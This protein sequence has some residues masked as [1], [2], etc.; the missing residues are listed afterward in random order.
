MAMLAESNM[1]CVRA[2]TAPG[3]PKDAYLVNDRPPDARF[4]A[5]ILVVVAHPDDET[6]VTSYL[7]REIYEEHKRV[8]VVYGTRGDAGN[9]EVGPENATAMGQIREIEA[10]QAVG[11]LGISNVWFLS[12][13]DTATQNVLNSLE[14]WG[15]GACLDELVRIIRLTRPAVILTFL[16][17]FATGEN[18]GDHQAAGV[19]AT[20]A[21][22]LAGDPAAFSE[23]VSPVSNP[24]GNM[25]LT[26]GLRPWQPEKIYYFYN[27]THDIFAGRGP[28]YSSSEVSPSQHVSYGLLAA[29][30]FVHHRTQGGDKVQQAIDDGSLDRSQD[31]DMRLITEPAK[32]IFGKSLVPS[33]KTDDV[34]AGVTPDGIA[35]SHLS[36]SDTAP[37]LEPALM[38]G[39]PWNYYR[40]FWK[41]HGLE[42][43]A[44][45][46]PPEMTVKVGS[47][48]N[49]PLIIENPLDTP[50]DVKVSAKAPDGWGAIPASTVSVGPHAR[51]FLRIRSA[52]PSTR[53]AG[54]QNFTVSAQ[55]SD[56]SIGT[57][58]IRVEL[59]TGWV[60]QL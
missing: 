33:S 2:Q 20:E 50:I 19:L 43:L 47:S 12:G 8:A 1:K 27:P 14:H 38:I 16:P 7:A 3:A 22:D 10:R 6:M 35:F 23:Q 30:V 32:F 57:V 5:D 39:D 18:H 13:R 11:S 45:I 4:K 55:T 52:A 51:Y 46:V 17:D 34:F 49:L 60:A 9:S 44:T 59:S 42:D 26:E 54:W 37:A 31:E 28:Q 25:N 41:E 29:R 53:L 15:H 40:I 36:Y 56:R 21:F 58:S 24:D 48:L